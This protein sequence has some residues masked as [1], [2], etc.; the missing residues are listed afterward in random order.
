M[1]TIH[2]IFIFCTLRCDVIVFIE[3]TTLRIDHSVQ[4]KPNRTF[5][6]NKVVTF[7]FVQLFWLVI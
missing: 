7:Y 3:L 6:R 4:N 1:L 5:L 2:I